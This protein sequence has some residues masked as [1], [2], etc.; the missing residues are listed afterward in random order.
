MYVNYY[1]NTSSGNGQQVSEAD[2]KSLSSFLFVGVV[3][4]S[5]WHVALEAYNLQGVGGA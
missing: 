3:Y 2:Y 5:F 4:H 1:T